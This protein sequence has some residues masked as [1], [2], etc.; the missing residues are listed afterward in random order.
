[1]IGKWSRKGNCTACGVNTGSNHSKGC[2][3]KITLKGSPRYQLID[4]HTRKPVTSKV[5]PTEEEARSAVKA[6]LSYK[7]RTKEIH[8]NL[9]VVV[10][11]D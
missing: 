10:K 3:L 4:Y 2:T 1:M 5:Y 7:A 11:N 9:I 6:Y 8:N